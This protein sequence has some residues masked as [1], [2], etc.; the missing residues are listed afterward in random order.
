MADLLE[1]VRAYLPEDRA[2]VVEEA[3]AFA[4]EVHEGQTRKSGEPYVDHPVSAAT[5]LAELSLDST[6]IV[7]ALLHDVV[8]DTDTTVDDV[9]VQFGDEVARLVDG[10]TKLTKLDLMVIE[11]EGHHGPTND[12]QAESVRKMLVAMAEDIRVVLIKLADRLHNMKTLKALPPH[13]RV[14]IAQET[15]DIYAPLAHRLGMGEMKWQLEDLAFRFIQP[16]QYRSISRLLASKRREREAYVRQVTD[17]LK[18]E[19]ERAGFEAEVTGRPKHI[20]SIYTKTQAYAT[21]G[22]ELGD[23]YDLFAVR[24]LVPT[25]QDCYG[26]LGVVHALWRPLPGQFDDYIANPKENAYQSLHT[27]VRSI[28]GLPVEVQVRTHE[29]HRISEYGVASHWRYKQGGASK[30]SQFEERMTWLRQLLEWQRD[31]SGTEEFLENVRTDIF[32]D[33][34]F[35][36]TPKNEI[37]ELPAGATPIDFAYRI[38]TDLGH[39]CIGAKVNGKLVGLDTQLKNGDTVEV[40]TSKVARGPSL[41]WLNPHLNFAITANARQAIRAWFR[42]EERGENIQRGGDLLKREL[43]RLNDDTDELEIAR[44]FGYETEEDL[45]AAIGIGVVSMAQV[46]GRLTA[47]TELTTEATGI[48]DSSL[49]GT[50]A[51]IT[52]LGV[53]DLLTRMG[54]CCH[55]LPGDD[56]VGYITRT[57]GITVHRG[58]C[59]NLKSIQD[60]ER[61]VPVSWGQSKN[62]YPVRIK[63]DAFDRVGLL[64]DITGATSIEHVNIRGSQTE[65]HNDNTVTVQ[66]TVQVAGLEQLSRLYSRIES[67]K[68]VHNVSRTIHAATP[69]ANN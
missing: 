43:R 48:D 14:A 39:R 31:V 52:V 61:M 7:A 62:V 4:H 35:A 32:R 54:E 22:K 10:V 27:S 42:R 3:L 49:V 44:I 26:V 23:I 53:G 58:D 40:L 57:R 17:V 18:H 11:D 68:G 65:V 64:H 12:G 6:T 15:L 30:D 66:I 59:P 2:K 56:I 50:T 13:R 28:G 60:Q 36:Y 33:Q 9:R 16:N 37:K 67:V 41:D 29:M 63:I 20:Y 19:L 47:R 21:Q 55:P 25:V 69:Q 51:G 45:L 24:V 1:T 8:E 46:A 5:Y 34:V 38:H